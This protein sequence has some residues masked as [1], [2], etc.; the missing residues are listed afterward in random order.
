MNFSG[1]L[2]NFHI[3][4]KKSHIIMEGIREAGLNSNLHLK[5]VSLKDHYPSDILIEVLITSVGL[6]KTN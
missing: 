3:I 2:V 6:S 1:L 5:V 4:K